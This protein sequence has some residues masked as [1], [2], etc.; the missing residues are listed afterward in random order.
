MSKKEPKQICAEKLE[1]SRAVIG[2][3]LPLS[4]TKVNLANAESIRQEMARV[5]R[6]ARAN[7]IDSADAAKL[8]YMLSQIAKAYEL[9][10]IEER[11]NALESTTQP[12]RI[13]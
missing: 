11:L 12:R 3:Y 2:E 5:Y 6:Q 7:K 4:P 8:I 13:R 9:G 10:V 1:E